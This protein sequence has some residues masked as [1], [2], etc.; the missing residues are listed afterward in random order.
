[1]CD[2]D[3]LSQSKYSKSRHPQP[4]PAPALPAPTA[5]S[6]QV[7]SG[8]V[9]PMGCRKMGCSLALQM[10]CWTKH[11]INIQQKSTNYG[12]PWCPALGWFTNHSCY[13][14]EWN[15]IP[16][17]SLVLW[18]KFWP[19]PSWAWNP[20]QWLI[21]GPHILWWNMSTQF[22]FERFEPWC[23]HPDL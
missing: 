8:A 15:K 5:A 12:C 22:G 13:E 20:E 11:E 23:C 10:E 16:A 6:K 21:M 18:A 14:K 19:K 7:W 1:M 2:M 9:N 3:L 4:P 17:G